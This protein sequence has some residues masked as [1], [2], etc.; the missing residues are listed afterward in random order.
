[1]D[2]LIE[3]NLTPDQAAKQIRKAKASPTKKRE[4]GYIKLKEKGPTIQKALKNKYNVKEKAFRGTPSPM[5]QRL[6][7]NYQ[8][9][10]AGQADTIYS[11][12]PSR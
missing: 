9:Y 3:K 10:S 7:L 2:Q 4:Y 5:P 1:M 8:Q 6:A 12:S 11:H